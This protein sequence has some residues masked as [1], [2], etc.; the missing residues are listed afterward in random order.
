MSCQRCRDSYAEGVADGVETAIAEERERVV[1]YLRSIPARAVLS[2]VES[3]GPVI[4]QL[5]T[6][7]ANG[8]HAKIE[9]ADPWDA[10]EDYHPES[11][12]KGD[13]NK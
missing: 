4:D 2:M 8:E 3:G 12:S 13:C 6:A 9:G 1:G 5:A 7:I 11:G 10:P